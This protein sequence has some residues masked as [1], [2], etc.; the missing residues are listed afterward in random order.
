MNEAKVDFKVEKRN[1]II[2]QADQIE[3]AA[4][5]LEQAYVKKTDFTIDE[6]EA[7]IEAKRKEF[8]KGV[9]AI[10]EVVSPPGK[11]PTGFIWV[12]NRGPDKFDWQF[13]SVSYS[14]DGHS[15]GLFTQIVGEHGKRRSL[16]SVD[17]LTNHSTHQ[18]A[19]PEDI[20]EYGRPMKRS[21]RVEVIDRRNSD[22]PAQL[23]TG[24]KTHIA[25]LNVEGNEESL[26]Q[27]VGTFTELT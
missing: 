8:G 24:E 14:L 9:K 7:M 10:G 12:Y 6:L 19:L 3:D 23:G 1:P 11:A 21:N 2:L 26:T 27:R 16:M 5:T 20:G 13:N 4:D 18:L 17:I 22:N 25:V 15:F